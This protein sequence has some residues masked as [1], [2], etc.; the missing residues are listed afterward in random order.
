MDSFH[1]YEDSSED[2]L[3]AW[4]SYSD[5]LFNP[6]A[7]SKRSSL[8][9]A[10]NRTSLTLFRLPD[11][12]PLEVKSV[13]NAPVKNSK[14][15]VRASAPIPWRNEQFQENFS[16]APEE[17][18]QN[19]IQTLLGGSITEGEHQEMDLYQE[20]LGRK[21]VHQPRFLSPPASRERAPNNRGS[22]RMS[23]MSI[24]SDVSAVPSL[25]FSEVDVQSR[26]PSTLSINTHPRTTALHRNSM[27]SL[28]SIDSMAS[29]RSW[30]MDDNSPSESPVEPI[31]LNKR[32]NFTRGV[33]MGMSCFD[34]G[35]DEED[36]DQVVWSSESPLFVPR[37]A[38]AS[39]E[40]Q[41]T[42]KKQSP[43]LSIETKV[44]QSPPN[45]LSP[46]LPPL[47]YPP[48]SPRSSICASPNKRRSRRRTAS[49]E[50]IVL[51]ALEKMNAV[52]HEFASE[53]INRKSVVGIDLPK[54]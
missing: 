30:F 18:L 44:P 32:V 31:P 52:M 50:C 23:I 43:G 8:R 37:G 24:A 13:R 40:L 21:N 48:I 28:T 2:E 11:Q 35:D 29:N 16:R 53:D 54:N 34:D 3:P 1:F 7:K 6:W 19:Y 38:E 5:I 20:C 33:E 12:S 39:L 15:P 51:E 26:R 49:S 41:T 46:S 14:K 25:V 22:K 4:D 27:V 45:M 9:E 36:E 17:D 47:T 42:R 10:D